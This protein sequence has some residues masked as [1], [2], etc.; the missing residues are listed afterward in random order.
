MVQGISAIVKYPMNPAGTEAL[1]NEWVGNSIADLIG[2]TIPKYGIC[3]I[4]EEVIEKS[5]VYGELDASNSGIAFFSEYLSNTAPG[6]PSMLGKASNKETEK[7]LLFDH[8]IK[9]EDRH[10][11]N[12]IGEIATT[13]R[14]FFIDCSHIMTDHL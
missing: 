2:L 5:D 1:I 4:S 6:T 7:L 8:L 3:K 11:G 10:N 13:R 14:I 9:N 12:L